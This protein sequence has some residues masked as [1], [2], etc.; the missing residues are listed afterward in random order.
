MKI[1]QINDIHIQS[2]SYGEDVKDA[3]SRVSTLVND[4]Q[5]DVLAIPGDIFDTVST[6]LQRLVFKTFL[7]SL[8]PETLVLI[9]PGNHDQPRD[10]M[11]FHKPELN[12]YVV[13]RPDVLMFDDLQV[14]FLP[15]FN[16]AT[17]ARDELSLADMAETGG[18]LLQDILADF[19]QKIRTHK[20]PSIVL[21]HGT[22]NGAE[23]D[24]GH[25]PRDNGLNFSA[26]A[27]AALGCPVMFGH[28]HK[29]QEMAH[30]VVY[31]GSIARLN[32]GEAEND[33]GCVIWTFEN[34]AW[35]WQFHSLAP[36]PMMNLNATW[37]SGGGWETDYLYLDESLIPGSRIRFIY[38]V[39][40]ADINQVDLSDIRE[41][42]REA[43][44]LKFEM[45]PKLSTAVRTVEI[46]EARTIPEKLALWARAKDKEGMTALLLA[47]HNELI[48]NGQSVE[49]YLSKSGS[50]HPS[51]PAGPSPDGPGGEETVT[52]QEEAPAK[53]PAVEP[54]KVLVGSFISG[55]STL[56]QSLF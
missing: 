48:N 19:F 43:H 37:V 4:K 11:I 52:S 16:P 12:R 28:Y 3:L 9:C 22:I 35:A 49:E 31:S 25:I 38:E 44:E 18:G 8:P 30:D 45:R 39:D 54:T 5:I 47:C 29:H 26:D 6:P 33:K 32:F 20:G 56:Q 40:E 2:G 17:I 34:N 1:L 13:E 10:L 36:R 51:D 14:C 27:L 7:D 24:N 55:P 46:A 50:Q 21:G 53:A 23:L 15:H 42:F 41:F